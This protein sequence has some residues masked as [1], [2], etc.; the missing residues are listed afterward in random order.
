MKLDKNK[1]M[2]KRQRQTI[3]EYVLIIAIVVLAAIGLLGLFSD[4]LRSKIAG[5]INT[6]DSDANA[7]STDESSEDIL[8]DLDDDGYDSGN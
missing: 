3:I 1:V 6:I 8:K 4:T 2:L 5:I 7:T